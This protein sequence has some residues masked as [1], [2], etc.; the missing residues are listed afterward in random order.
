M[1]TD[2]LMVVITFV[3]VVATIFICVF[4]YRSAQAARKQ[5]ELSKMQYEDD[6]RLKLMPCLLIRRASSSGIINGVV[7]YEFEHQ[8]NQELITGEIVFTVTNVGS[9]IAQKIE[10]YMAPG[11]RGYRR[12]F[13]ES[14]PQN[15]SRTVRLSLSAVNNTTQ[16]L[17]IAISYCDLLDHA[18]MQTL[19]VRLNYI[20]EGMQLETYFL[21]AP[22]HL[23][24]EMSRTE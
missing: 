6:V 7:E 24:K 20:D 23:K 5:N 17:N 1:T 4:N 14:M 8:G 3:Y 11:T 22:Q 21:S 9:G 2:W 12:Y 15:D 10:Y 19:T 18:Y 13:V 16:E